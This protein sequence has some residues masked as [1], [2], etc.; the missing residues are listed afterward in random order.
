MKDVGFFSQASGITREDLEK[1]HP[2]L[3]EEIARMNEAMKHAYEDD[4]ASLHLLENNDSLRTIKTLVN[5]KF[6]REKEHLDRV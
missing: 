2:N 4:R 6:S 5:E 1:L 3:L